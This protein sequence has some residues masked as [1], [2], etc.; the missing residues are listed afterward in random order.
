M[1]NK[2]NLATY[3]MVMNQKFDKLS[4]N[5]Q[6]KIIQITIYNSNL[7]ADLFI[8]QIFLPNTQKE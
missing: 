1:L 6:T 8:L 7:L 5:Q 4:M 3:R 2:Q